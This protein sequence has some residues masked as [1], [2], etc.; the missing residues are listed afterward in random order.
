[1]KKQIGKAQHSCL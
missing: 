1:M